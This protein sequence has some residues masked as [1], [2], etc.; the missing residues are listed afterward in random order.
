[1]VAGIVYM[2][3]FDKLSE[4]TPHDTAII[5]SLNNIEYDEFRDNDTHYE[6]VDREKKYYASMTDIQSIDNDGNSIQI[7]FDVNYFQFDRNGEYIKPQ[8]QHNSEFIVAINEDQTFVARCNSFSIR[9]EPATERIPV[10]QVHI[11][12]YEGITEKDGVNYYGFAH[13]ADYVPDH[14]EC[15]FPEMIQYSLDIDF[16]VGETNFY[17]DVWDNDWE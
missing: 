1:M 10:K 17:G 13:E 4:Q 11:L 2:S 6:R 14:I 3:S 9:D 5:N 8:S 12:R 15:K 16:D 7:T